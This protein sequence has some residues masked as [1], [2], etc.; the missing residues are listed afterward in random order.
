MGQS[1]YCPAAANIVEDYSNNNTYYHKASDTYFAMVRR[2]NQFFQQQYQIGFDG[3]RVNLTE[4]KV[5]YIL[6]SGIHARS[7]LALTSSN[8][9]IMMPLGWY[10]EKGGSWAMN[11]GYDRPDHQGSRRA[12]TY[13]CMFCHNGYPEIPPETTRPVRRRLF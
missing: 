13:D 3:K 4:K 6:G 7:Y 5:D 9:L 8:T 2:G 11:P 10:A 12:V 1:F